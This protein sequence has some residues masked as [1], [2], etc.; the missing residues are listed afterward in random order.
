MEE[1]GLIGWN[2][3]KRCTG[4]AHSENPLLSVFMV[5][6]RDNFRGRTECTLSI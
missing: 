2:E 6:V 4:G 3:I 1:I 5:S